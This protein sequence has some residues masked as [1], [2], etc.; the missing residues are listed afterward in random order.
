MSNWKDAT[1]ARNTEERA[2]L[3]AFFSPEAEAERFAGYDRIAPRWREFR[4]ASSYV[5]SMRSRYLERRPFDGAWARWATDQ[6]FASRFTLDGALVMMKRLSAAGFRDYSLEPEVNG[7]PNVTD[8]EAN[9]G[10]LEMNP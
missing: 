9:A 2:R 8:E 1:D 10:A 3:D 5:I 7:A 6:R 4:D